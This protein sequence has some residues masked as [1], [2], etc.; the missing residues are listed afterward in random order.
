MK[1][2]HM[3]TLSIHVYLSTIHLYI[4]VYIY[5][6]QQN[7]KS[8]YFW[9]IENPVFIFFIIFYTFSFKELINLYAQV[10]TIG[11]KSLRQL[12]QGSRMHLK[13]STG[14]YATECR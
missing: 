6:T 8:Y 14:K 11:G 10:N 7:V 4:Y 13:T 2:T 1:F 3:H 5:N 12:T 9:I